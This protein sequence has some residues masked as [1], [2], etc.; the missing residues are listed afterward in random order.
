MIISKDVTHDSRVNRHA[1]ALGAVGHEVIVLCRPS[2]TN[3]DRYETRQHYKVIRYHYPDLQVSARKELD[4]HNA[5]K[6][7]KLSRMARFGTLFLLTKLRLYLLALRLRAHV[8]YCNDLD[9][10]DV[11]IIMKFAGRKV[12]YDSHE[13]YIEALAPGER[14]R[15]YTLFERLFINCANVLITVNQFIAKELAHRY[16]ITKRIHVVLNCPESQLQPP[17]RNSSS[18]VTVLYHGGLD[19]D[20]GLENLVRA[21]ERFREDIRLVIRGEGMLEKVL[22]QL[23]S[24]RCHVSFE[25]NVPVNQVVQ[26]AADADVGVIPYLPTNLNNYFCSPNKLFEYIQAGLAVVTSDLPYLRQFVV[27]NGVGVI[28]DPRI[29]VDIAQKVNF[30]CEEKILQNFKQRA[31][32]VRKYYTWERERSRLYA[33]I[34]DLGI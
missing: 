17:S 14:R 19:P 8:Y 7:P 10:L 34:K 2:T 15:L 3:Q 27:E 4:A 20:R 31:R 9:T 5:G 29:P 13:L 22:K 33:A 18:T 6:L 12:I 24:T 26:K 28:F 16:K 25:R 21:S 32:E 1:T 30:V 11:G 23:A